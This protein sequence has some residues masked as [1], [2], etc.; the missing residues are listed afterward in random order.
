MRTTKKIVL[1]AAFSLLLLSFTQCTKEAQPAQ[2]QAPQTESLD[3]VQGIKIAYVEYDSLMAKYLLAIDIHKEM[4]RKETNINNT[5]EQK[6]NSLQEEQAEFTRKYQNNVFA[7]AERA[8]EEYERLARKEQEIL[9]LQQTLV[10][11]Y[12]NELQMYHRQLRDS[13]NNYIIEYNGAK[14]YDYIL[15]KVGDNILYAN[16]ALD[17]TQEIVDG[18]NSRYAAP[19]PAE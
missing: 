15:T 11:E 10:A 1:S 12:E 17:I 2:P 5:I 19:Q 9:Q 7:T 8:Q 4:M 13:V 16:E 3:S 14:G 18:L 6:A